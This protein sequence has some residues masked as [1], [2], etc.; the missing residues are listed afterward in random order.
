[1]TTQRTFL[2]L[3]AAVLL[4]PLVA[5]AQEVAEAEEAVAAPAPVKV[6][7]SGPNLVVEPRVPGVAT[8][9]YVSCA[10]GTYIHRE[11]E[12]V[13]TALVELVGD[14]G[15]PVADGRCKYEVYVH[16]PVDREAMRAAEEA[17]DL[18]TVR[19]LSRIEKEQTVITHGRF[20]VEGG[21]AVVSL[22]PEKN[23]SAQGDRK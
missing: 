18:A 7:G 8:S 22:E 9:V 11:F 2:W 19:R 16:P 13:G 4:V 20:L 12:G 15:T 23:P 1:M 10:D 6:N 14:D 21:A 5:R 3:I 17:G